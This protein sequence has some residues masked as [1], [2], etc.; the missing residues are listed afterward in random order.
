MSD[1][2]NLFDGCDI[3]LLNDYFIQACEDGELD[4]VKYL[5]TSPNLAE[6]VSISYKSDQALRNACKHGHLDIVKYLLTSS[7]LSI[8]ANLHHDHDTS[9]VLACYSGNLDLVKYLLTSEELSSHPNIHT[10]YMDSPDYALTLACQ[11]GYI[12]I[13][14][15]LVSSNELTEHANIHADDDRPLLSSYKNGHLD[16]VRFFIFDMNMQKSDALI[17]YLEMENIEEIENWF[18]LRELNKELTAE[19]PTNGI[20]KNNKIKL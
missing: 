3:W 16:I 8:H 9:F 7:D 10:I 5:L 11:K 6:N 18:K 17:V 20:A 15:Y 2:F 4:K 13:V 1:L 19:I 14:K 12:E